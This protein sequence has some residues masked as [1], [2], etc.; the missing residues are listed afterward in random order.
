M[1]IPEGK[2]AE[3]GQAEAG[4]RHGVGYQAWPGPSPPASIITMGLPL[5]VPLTSGNQVR[6]QLPELSQGR[7]SREDT[8]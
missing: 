8:S 2:K 5:S 6:P 7:D 1:K 3:L 4:W